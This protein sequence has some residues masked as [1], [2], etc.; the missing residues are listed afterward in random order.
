MFFI[1]EIEKIEVKKEEEIL[2]IEIKVLVK[3]EEFF[4]EKLEILF[5]QGIV[6]EEFVEFQR[7]NR[8][9]YNIVIYLYQRYYEYIFEVIVDCKEIY[10]ICQDIRF[11][12]RY[13]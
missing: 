6:K 11:L 5:F 7:E 3:E 2:E 1:L 8:R 10:Y 12:F 13:L 4:E 9:L